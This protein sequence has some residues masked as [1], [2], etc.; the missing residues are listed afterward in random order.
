MRSVTGA[1][2][3]GEQIVRRTNMYFE[4]EFRAAYT[5]NSG[6]GLHVVAVQSLHILGAVRTSWLTR[7]VVTWQTS[8]LNVVTTLLMVVCTLYR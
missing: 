8:N 5:N 1:L 7:K 6:S 3:C 2:T 4:G